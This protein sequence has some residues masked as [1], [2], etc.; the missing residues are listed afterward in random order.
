MN[1]FRFNGYSGWVGVL[2]LAGFI[3]LMTPL[4]VGGLCLSF[5][6]V[7]WTVFGVSL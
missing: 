6:L 2:W 7:K 3:A 5:L 1:N 4:V